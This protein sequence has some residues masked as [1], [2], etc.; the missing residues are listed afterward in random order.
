MR[1]IYLSAPQGTPQPR[2]HLLSSKKR[3]ADG[4]QQSGSYIRDAVG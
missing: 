4:Q 2:R 3:I 1:D